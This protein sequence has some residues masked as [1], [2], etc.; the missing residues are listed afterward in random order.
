[1]SRLADVPALQGKRK[2]LKDV[3][4]FVGNDGN[5][6]LHFMVHR[7]V[8]CL[9]ALQGTKEE[10]NSF[11]GTASANVSFANAVHKEAVQVLESVLAVV[12]KSLSILR[13]M[14]FQMSTM[15]IDF[16]EQHPWLCSSD[17]QRKANTSEWA[18]LWKRA[19]LSLG[20]MKEGA[21][22]ARTAADW[23]DLESTE[24]SKV[25]KKAAKT[26]AAELSSVLEKFYTTTMIKEDDIF[27]DLEK[28]NLDKCQN[29]IST[30]WPGIGADV[31]WLIFRVSVT[32]MSCSDAVSHIKST[33]VFMTSLNV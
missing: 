5:Q 14:V 6:A 2:F 9:G 31:S 33:V 23:K 24:L 20:G 15:D 12:A 17:E 21:I 1:M 27:F 19:V 30:Q 29:M 11:I 3:L 4:N 22:K 8:Y 26:V 18:G 32:A 28:K 13:T 25:S 7:T 10:L 16:L